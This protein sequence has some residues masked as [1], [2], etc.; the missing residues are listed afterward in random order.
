MSE[1]LRGLTPYGLIATARAQRIKD[2]KQIADKNERVGT[3]QWEAMQQFIF[4]E[5]LKAAKGNPVL[6][7]DALRLFAQ[8][9][10][11]D[12]EI[13]SDIEDDH[14]NNPKMFAQIVTNLFLYSVEQIGAEKYF[15]H[16]D[17]FLKDVF[18]ASG[19]KVQ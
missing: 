16:Y 10:T 8:E 18:V 14:I 6:A 15:D 9:H 1:T 12:E 3:V 2:V 19:G 17:E 13:L 7:Y 5:A 11:T 4:D